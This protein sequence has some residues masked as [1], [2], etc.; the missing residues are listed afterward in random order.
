MENNVYEKFLPVGSVVLLKEAKKKLMITGFCL[1]SKQ[2]VDK[3]YDYCA[4][5]YPEGVIS[6]ERS[7]LFN[8]NQIE[9]VFA[10]GYSDDDDKEY[11]KKLLTE[12]NSQGQSNV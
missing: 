11:R 6:S 10:I 8:H 5:I 3:V 1:V 4:C 2:N 9:K 7:I 12:I